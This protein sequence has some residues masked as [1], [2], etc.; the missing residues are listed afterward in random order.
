M[1]T[2]E[3]SA[4]YRYFSDPDIPNMNLTKDFIDSVIKNPPELP[5]DR[6]ERYVASGLS[7][8]EASHIVKSDKWV[9]QLFEDMKINVEN[10]RSAYLWTTGELL[11]QLR[12]LNIESKP[13]H[14]RGDNFGELISLVDEGEVSSS[15]GKEI[16]SELIQRDFSPKDYAKSNNLIQENSEEYINNLI[17]KVLDSHDEIVE[18]IKSGEDKLVGFLVGEVMK[19]SSAS[20]NPSLVRELIAK[21]TK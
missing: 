7:L 13:E 4:D 16:L 2:K 9:R 20:L 17:L 10:I 18:R 6:R 19:E 15:T 21:E 1:R 11:G 12:K 14:L 3:G 5:K 8:E